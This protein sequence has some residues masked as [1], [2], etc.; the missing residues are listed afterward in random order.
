MTIEFF[1]EPDLNYEA[2]DVQKIT[3]LVVGQVLQLDDA[4]HTVKRVADL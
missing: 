1:L 2:P 3:A 4:D